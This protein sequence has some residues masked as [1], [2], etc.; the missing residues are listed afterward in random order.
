MCS[1]NRT[2]SKL[3]RICRLWRYGASGNDVI[4]VLVDELHG[5]T[6][7]ERVADHGGLADAEFVEQIAE[8]HR[9]R[10]QRSHCGVSRPAVAHGQTRSP[11][12]S[13]TAAVSPTARSPNFPPYRGS[14]Q[15]FPVTSSRGRPIAVQCQELAR[16]FCRVPLLV[17]TR[18][19]DDPMCSKTPGAS[20]GWS[21]GLVERTTSLYLTSRKAGR[22]L[23]AV[24]GAI[25]AT[26]TSSSE[27][28]C[29]CGRNT[30]WDCVPSDGIHEPAENPPHLVQRSWQASKP[31]AAL[32][33]LTHLPVPP[34]SPAATNSMNVR[35]PLPAFVVSTS[36]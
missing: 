24:S 28:T 19:R 9:E 31:S 21:V 18:Q 11:G 22:R 14:A 8:K 36:G 33:H 23:I 29:S 34:P 3:A 20:Q 5:D 2:T 12:I 1:G 13:S 27:P 25:C 32:R 26:G 16:S 15:H 4:G 6:T 17:L 10:A 7:A 30:T 35:S